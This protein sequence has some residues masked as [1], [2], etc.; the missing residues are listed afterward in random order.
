MGQQQLGLFRSPRSASI[1]TPEPLAIAGHI[2]ITVS[3]SGLMHWHVAR[4]DLTSRRM[5]FPDLGECHAPVR[6]GAWL[7]ECLNSA[8]LQFLDS[9]ACLGA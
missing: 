8:T 9:D 3:E 2:G 7:A 4:L 1:L 6:A 5:V